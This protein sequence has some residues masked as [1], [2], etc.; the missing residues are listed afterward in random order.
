MRSLASVFVC[1]TILTIVPPV[2]AL[3]ESISHQSTT[4]PSDSRFEII[5]SMLLAKVTLRVDKFT[6]D[7]DQLVTTKTGALSWQR[8]FREKHPKDTITNRT[9]VNYQV[10]AS[11]LLAK[12]TILLNLN[13]GATWQLVDD[14]EIGLFWDAFQ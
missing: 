7:I 3:D 13:T 2:L 10:F 5:Q 11:G 12:C 9:K 1:I 8:L 14:P 6:G 4:V